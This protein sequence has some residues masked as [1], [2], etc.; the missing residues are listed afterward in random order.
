MISTNESSSN[1]A[2]VVK[3]LSACAVGFVTFLVFLPTLQN[4]FINWDDS[5]YVY[6]NPLIRSF[7]TQLLISAFG[8]FYAGFWHPLTWIS[9]ALDYAIWGLNPMGHHLTNN[10]LHAINAFLVVILITRLV[11]AAS[12]SLKSS[13]GSL[14]AAVTTGLLFGLHPLRVESVAWVAERKDLLCGLFYLLSIMAYTSYAANKSYRTYF[15][16]LG[17]FTLALM[18]KPMAV[19]L[20]VVLLILDWYPFRRIESIKSFWNII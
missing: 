4:D 8:D 18:S 9:H 7:D 3:Y 20:P 1:K 5:L 13:K 12:G 14:V 2:L 10:I 6:E 17:L 16:S 15:I 19:S 11:E